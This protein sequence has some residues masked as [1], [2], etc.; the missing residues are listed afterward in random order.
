ME[1]LKQDSDMEPLKSSKITQRVVYLNVCE[2]I[3]INTICTRVKE[4]VYP[5]I[6]SLHT[7]GPCRTFSTDIY[8]MKNLLRM[9]IDI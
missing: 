9:H 6:F 4:C 2:L 1:T 3:E 8:R 5:D 7:S